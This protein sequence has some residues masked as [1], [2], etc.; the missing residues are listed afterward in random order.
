MLIK[1]VIIPK[2]ENAGRPKI[3]QKQGTCT[4]ACRQRESPS[5]QCKTSHPDLNAPLWP[6]QSEL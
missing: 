1:I 2:E 5:T 4:K 6:C 3:E